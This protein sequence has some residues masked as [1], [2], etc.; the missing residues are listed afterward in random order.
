MPLFDASPIQ[1]LRRMDARAVVALIQFWSKPG[2]LRLFLLALIAISALTLPII[3]V[4]RWGVDDYGRSILGYND[5]V[6]AGRPVAAFLLWAINLGSLTDTAPLPQF[7]AVVFMAIATLIIAERFSVSDKSLI[8]LIA[9]CMAGNPY[10][11]ENI[12][13]RFDS[14]PMALAILLSVAALPSVSCHPSIITVC[15][16]TALLLLALCTYQYSTNYYFVLGSFAIGLRALKDEAAILWRDVSACYLPAV[17]AGF[18][19]TQ[20]FPYLTALDGHNYASPTVLAFSY[21]TQQSQLAVFSEWPAA[22]WQNLK[23]VSSIFYSDWTHT[24]IGAF[25]TIN[26]FI[27]A[28]IVARM[29]AVRRHFVRA[30][31]AIGLLCLSVLG[32][33][34]I[35]LP[36]ST[37]SLIARTLVGWGAFLAMTPIALAFMKPGI[38]RVLATSILAMQVLATLSLMFSLRNALAN[39][40]QY[41]QR[42]VD[43]IANEISAA[44]VD[45]QFKF[46]AISGYLEAPAA[47]AQTSLKYPVARRLAYTIMYDGF[48][49]AVR[50]QWSGVSLEF[51]DMPAAQKHDVICGS[52]PAVVGT[53]YFLFFAK[54]TILLRFK[55]DGIA[56][57]T[58]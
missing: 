6:A 37:P 57:N 46:L 48:W 41:E 17:V 10:F 54:D 44:A 38:L 21:V 35:Q 55:T 13:F 15:L 7:I 42:V 8:F 53:G 3:G 14:A 49:A 31:I 26:F 39:Q 18:V 16:S 20:L 58:E 36:L 5:L 47:A 29:I 45:R 25:W 9:T 4:G 52:S 32:V 33:V 51:I 50:L 40:L 28:S 43:D 19:Y 23:R 56:C 34:G 24:L 27:M 22:I 1:R 11:V 2:I 30:A 12:S